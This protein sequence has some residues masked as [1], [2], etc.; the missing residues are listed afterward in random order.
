MIAAALI[1][2]AA[3]VLVVLSRQINGRL[4]LSTSALTASFWNHAVGAAALTLA[5]LLLGGLFAGAPLAAPW[6]AFLG[7][8]VGVVFIAL[9]SWLIT[10]IGAAQTALLIIA[11]QMLSGVALDFA[12]GAPGDPAARLAGI[13][14]IAAGVA[15]ARR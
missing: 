8:P 4:S 13:A 12:L 5:A 9:S 7:G 1:A 2:F 11:G 10:R 6:W 14:L 3:G 15:L